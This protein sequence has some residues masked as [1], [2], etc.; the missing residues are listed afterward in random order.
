MDHKVFWNFSL[1]P[2]TLRR[3]ELGIGKVRFS[4]SLGMDSYSTFLYFISLFIPWGDLDGGKKACS[5]TILKFS[6]V[7]LSSRSPRILF[8]LALEALRSKESG[9]EK[10]GFSMASGICVF[11]TFKVIKRVSLV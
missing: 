6:S 4:H 8:C 3:T 10:V 5:I 9:I 7:R 11:S 2:G 1:S